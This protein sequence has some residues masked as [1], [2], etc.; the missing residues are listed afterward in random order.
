[1]LI[2]EKKELESGDYTLSWRK[3][4]SQKVRCSWWESYLPELSNL[5]QGSID[6]NWRKD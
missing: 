4:C 2:K 6:D 1:M 5:M 3:R